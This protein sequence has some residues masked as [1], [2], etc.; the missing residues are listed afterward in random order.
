VR[1][2]DTFLY[3]GEADML[4][5]RLATLAGKVD[6]FVAVEATETF[7]GDPKACGLPPSLAFEYPI[8][9]VTAR[10]AW[11]ADPWRREFAQREWVRLGLEQL[12]VQPDDLI[13]HGDVDEIPRPDTIAQLDP[14]GYQSLLMSMRC[15]AL[16]WL[17]PGWW[18][19]TVAAYYRNLQDGFGVA[20]LSREGS[21][22]GATIQRVDGVDDAGWH[23]SYLG[24]VRAKLDSYSHTEFRDVD[25]EFLHKCR[26][27]GIHINGT[28][29]RPLEPPVDVP[30][31]CLAHAPRGWWRP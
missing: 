15:F 2:F 11:S 10:L 12:H 24:D 22:K 13:L 9:H 21:Q 29:L 6:H 16:D 30:D 18:P 20:R 27:A 28:K 17:H 14:H 23:L 31:W 8:H 3:S 4:E 5:C 25:D 19:G 7:Q 26:T 1:V